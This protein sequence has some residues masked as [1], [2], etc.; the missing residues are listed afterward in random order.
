MK[1][2]HVKVTL[3]VFV[4]ADE[5]ADVVQRLTASGFIIDPDNNA[6]DE[7]MDVQDVTVDDVEVTDSR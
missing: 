2:V 7:V 3:D 1:K 4:V 5:F 6:L